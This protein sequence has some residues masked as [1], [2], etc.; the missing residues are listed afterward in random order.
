MALTAEQWFP[1]VIWSGMMDGVNNA[2]IET[3]ANDRKQLD[4]GVQ[5]SNYI[6]WQSG[7]IRQ[8]DN[9]E[10]DKLVGA[11]TDQVNGCAVQADIPEL[12]IQNIWININT[13]GSYNHLHNHAGSILS[14]VYYVK[15]TPEQGNIFFERGDNAEYFLPPMEKPNYF[16]S[17]ATTYKAMTNALYIFPGWL[18]HSVQPNLTD[19][20]RI[21]VSFNYGAK[22]NAN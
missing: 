21:S 18:K 15:A 13:P 20:N 1:S 5:V 11:I 8:G 2:H 22:P 14:G 12:A 3:F 17:T 6:G 10:F 19:E 9:E 4:E 7:P 16:T